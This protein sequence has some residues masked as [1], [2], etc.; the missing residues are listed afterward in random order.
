LDTGERYYFGPV[1]FEQNLLNN[2]FLH[3]FVP[4]APG[5]PYNSEKLI[6]MQLALSESEYYSQI[7][8]SAPHG[9]ATRKSVLA[10]WFLN[11]MFPERQETLQPSGKLEIPV[12]VEAKPSK[13][14]SYNISL[15]YGTDTG[16]RLGFGLKLRHI[17]RY[18]HQFRINTRLSQIERTLH[19]A[20]DIPIKDVTQ[21]RLS[22]TGTISNE[23]YGDITSTL[24]GV[25]VVRDTHWALGRNRFYL[26]FE[27][28]YYDLGGGNRHSDLL[29][30]GY[31]FTLKKADNLMF[32]HN[33][34]SL[35]TDVRGASSAL[36]SS[37]DF[38]R[39]DV[40]A[41]AVYSVI[42]SIRFVFRSEFG[43]ITASD[44]SDVPPSQ[45]FFAGGARSVRG[46]SYQKISPENRAGDHIGGRYLVVGSIET[47]WFFYKKFGIAAFFDAGDVENSLSD[48]DF[49]KGAGLGFRWGSPVGMVRFDIAYPF[50]SSSDLHIHFS[51]GPDL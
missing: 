35:M 21:D 51:L 31:H 50:D 41:N 30:P 18:G 37:T 24:Y 22:F 28:E 2:K 11:L 42:P 36:G 46:Y 40:A 6:D 45:R 29:Y 8:I 34:V 14:Q 27:R 17:N 48:I 4:F 47:D 9:Q 38:A 1:T 7:N 19:A 23:D 12:T 49:K 13:S 32:T 33:G 16:P 20:Y 3:K 44:F 5:Q 25:G 39:A 15:G 26:K 10:P 43:A